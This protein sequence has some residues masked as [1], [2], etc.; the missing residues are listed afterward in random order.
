M[1]YRPEI[2]GLRA[3]AVL[4]VILYHLGVITTGV[5]FAGVDIFFVISGYLIGGQIIQQKEAGTFRFK[6]FYARRARRI[7]PA[8]FVV[9]LVTIV[10]GWLLMLPRDYRYFLGGAGTALLSL[11]NFWFAARIDYFNPEAAEDPLV[12]TWTLG[13]EEQFYLIV[14]L[15][16][17]V[18]WKFGRPQLFTVLTLLALASF[19]LAL[20]MSENSPQASYYLLPTRAW[21][22]LAG[23]LIALKEQDL[24]ALFRGHTRNVFATAS[25]VVLMVGIVAIPRDVNWPGVF[26]IVP[27]AAAA[28]LIA[29]GT[30]ETAAARVLSLSGMR[31]IG[32]LSYSAYLIHQP[33]LGFLAYVDAGPRTLVAKALVFVATFLLAYLSWRYVETPFRMKKMRPV[34]GRGMLIAAAS[35]IFVVCVGGAM[36][37]GYP[38]RMSAEVSQILSVQNTFGPNNKRCLLSRKDVPGMDITQACVIGPS[39]VAS[40]ALWGDSHGAAIV[41]ALSD[42]LVEQGQTTKAHL[43]ASCLPVP[44]LVMFGQKRTEQCASF[45]AQV[46]ASIL[47]DKYIEV[48]VLVAT[49]DNY[50][51][52]EDTPDMF[53]RR[54]EDGF[55]AY[56]V[57]ASYSIAEDERRAALQEAVY[58][59]LSKLTSAGK[60]VVVVQSNPRPDVSIPRHVARLVKNGSSSPQTMHYDK[61]H[62]DAQVEFSRELFLDILG[63][64]DEKSVVSVLPEDVLCTDEICRIVEDGALLFSDGNHLSVDG[65]RRVAPNI[66]EAVE[67]L[68]QNE[69]NHSE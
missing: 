13:V 37:K 40:V 38:D 20:W 31:G 69:G 11:S 6:D 27:V 44:N 45:N 1:Q 28:F 46:L 59:L 49:W 3:V 52:S 15:L 48:V 29:L 54:G 47:A 62:F 34:W 24:R 14:P 55:Y 61:S 57:G 67:K 41:D 8:L 4:S 7:L 18:I 21:E 25:L 63:Q 42:N 9:I 56:P 68:V 39:D 23:V 60:S 36:T 26:T 32:L 43:L 5:G 50:F 30:R 12:H 66:A 2:D 51:M 64:F 10:I 35:L 16:I 58:D 33:I 17:I 22:L 19:G 65:A 53:G